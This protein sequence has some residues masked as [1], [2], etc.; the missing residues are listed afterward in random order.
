MRRVFR[1]YFGSLLFGLLLLTSI[2]VGAAGGVLFVYNSDLPEVETLAS[3]RPN[4]VTEVYGDDGQI[5]GSFALERRIIVEP[6]QI[7]QVLKDAVV[8]VEDQNFYTHW[9]LD[10]VGISRAALK[11]ILAGRVVEGGSTITQQLS[12]NVFLSPKREWALKIQ[13][14][15]LSIQI[16]RHYSKEEILTLYCNQIY[17]GHGMYG[18]AAAAEF[19]FGKNLE[20]LTIEEAATL[21][22]LPRAPGTYSPVS[23][24]ERSLM[25]RNYAIDRM[26]AEGS[27]D[28]LVGEQAK[29]TPIRLNPRPA[30][31][32]LAP[33][34]LEALRQYL[35]DAY[36]TYAVHE[37][38][39]RVYSTLNAKLQ[40]D[41]EAALRQGLRDYDKR[42]GWRGAETN[43]IEQGVESL[44]TYLLPGWRRPLQPGTLARGIVLDADSETA[45]IK[46]A[47]YEDTI[48]G[49]DIAWTRERSPSSLLARGDVATFLIREINP[50]EKSIDVVLDQQPAV[51]G[52]VVVIEQTTGEVKAMVGGYD[53]Q[54]DQ[55]NRAT[56]ALRQ[57]G[58]AFKPLLYTAALESGLGPNTVIVDEPVDFDG[59]RPTNYD[60]TFAGPVTLRQAL[61][62]SRNVPAV[63]VLDEIGF[64]RLIPLVQRFGITT[65]IE[66]YLP[67]ALGATDVTL[68]EMTSAYST[69]PNGGVRIA[70][71][72]INRVTDYDG[73][74]LEENFPEPHDVVSADIARQM[75]D[76]LEEVVKTGTGRRAQ[77]LGRPAAGKTGT[78]NDFTD[79]WFI[80]FTP[81]LTAGVWVGFNEK[82]PLGSGETGGV[83]ALPIWLSLMERAHEGQPVEDFRM[84]AGL[85]GDG[86]SQ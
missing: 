29:Q 76:L 25:R 44:D 17:L 77:S 56:Q 35:E 66:R 39:L 60:G 73:D 37:R 78:T 3:Y 63:R 81:S 85:S 71:R 1:R 57:T 79:A 38:G 64:E 36:G 21:A 4:V 6:G 46:I 24:P 68:I 16:E 45:R 34:F 13:E 31:E 11:N 51:E 23:D 8:A 49:A 82:V 74:V 59:Y 58:S 50:A 80:G 28:A 84:T 32:S 54:R 9:G 42:H 20:D 47:D 22:A 61:A 52:A 65:P 15:L 19:Y 83:T 26:V 72:L 18:F 70:P 53:F 55:F 62:Q 75:V 7:P 41:A 86:R 27:V 69:F 43:L 14:A 33:Y 2:T 30:S 48:E 10:F 40:R 12:E 5:I 67:I